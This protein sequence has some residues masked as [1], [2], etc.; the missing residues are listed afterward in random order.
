MNIGVGRFLSLFKNILYASISK[1]FTI[2]VD[3]IY[4]WYT[5]YSKRALK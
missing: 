4:Y 3:F 5:F 2:S 1:V